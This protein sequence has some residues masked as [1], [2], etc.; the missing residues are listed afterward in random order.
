[1]TKELEELGAKLGFNL[2]RR[3]LSGES[4]FLGAKR[5][6]T[7]GLQVYDVPTGGIQ[8]TR[9][10]TD[11][12]DHDPDEAAESKS[13]APVGQPLS[14]RSALPQV[15]GEAKY[16]DDISSPPGTFTLCSKF[17]S[18]RKYSQHRSG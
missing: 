4:H 5:P 13:R 11:S 14:H 18:T 9:A 10:K 16:T 6:I 7:H 8:K 2:D 12:K 15:T 1:M 17:R 3:D